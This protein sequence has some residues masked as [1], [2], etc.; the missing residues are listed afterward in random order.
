MNAEIVSIGTEL[1]LGH[2]V[3][4][5]AAYLSKELAKAGVNV[6]YH[7]VV[8]DDRERLLATL[9]QAIKRSELVIT[10][11]GL[12][13]TVDDITVE[14][15]ADISKRKLVFKPQIL[16]WIKLRFSKRGIAFPE[17]NR[18]QAYIPEG[19]IAMKNPSGT[20]PGLILKMAKNRFLIALPGVPGEMKDITQTALVPFLKR[21]IKTRSV[22][23]SKTLKTVGLPESVVNEKVA[24]LLKL[25][26]EVTMGIY[27]HPGQVDLRITA[28][29]K[30]KTTAHKLIGKV[31]TEIIRRLGKIIYGK[32]KDTM[33]AVVGKLLKKHKKNLAIAESCTGGLVT[34]RITNVPGSSAY[35]LL[36]ITAY[37][38]RIKSAQL[39]I[40]SQIIK[41]HG[42]VSRKVAL[43]LAEGTRRLAK[44]NIALG[45]TGI[46]GPAGGTKSK[47]VGTVYIALTANNFQ[48]VKK[49]LFLG[50]RQAI[51]LRTSQAALDMIRK[52]LI[53]N[54]ELRIKKQ[55]IKY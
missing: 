21:K 1:L 34:H 35:F 13:P 49:H 19:A 25:G 26:P 27:P 15:L 10:T 39:G 22:I 31:E 4:T 44:S 30:D 6:Y 37:S 18:R 48:E 40:H 43:S 32:D 41:K 23:V 16:R 55:P 3:N 2:T 28:R 36:G 17:V 7:M 45:I 47:P 9:R 53:T 14:A 52:Y 50:N 24:D 33:E 46:A 11:G 38:N 54:Y 12:G 20:A 29:A 8:G 5:N 42:A 51:K